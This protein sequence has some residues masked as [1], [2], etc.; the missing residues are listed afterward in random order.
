MSKI[1]KDKLSEKD[2]KILDVIV[3]KLIIRRLKKDNISYNNEKIDEI[4]KTYNNMLNFI[5]ENSDLKELYRFGFAVVPKSF[6]DR[7][8]FICYDIMKS[9]INLKNKHLEKYLDYLLILHSSIDIYGTSPLHNLN[10]YM[11][12]IIKM[13]N[14][15]G[16]YF[17]VEY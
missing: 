12:Q 14:V 7:E 6:Y 11:R 16:E 17:I 8:D 2:K 3:K 9:I 15:I 1:E 10:D 5:Y 13:Y 4:I